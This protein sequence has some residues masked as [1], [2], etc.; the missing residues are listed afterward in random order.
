M[1]IVLLAPDLE[2]LEQSLKMSP[3]PMRLILG[4]RLEG[5]EFEEVAVLYLGIVRLKTPSA[6]ALENLGEGPR[7]RSRRNSRRR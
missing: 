3:T 7:Y 5:R 2:V 1:T 6:R 4:E